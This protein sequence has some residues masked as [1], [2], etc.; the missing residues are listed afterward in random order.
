VIY[1]SGNPNLK[2]EK[3][4][5]TTVGFVYQ[6]RWG[7]DWQTSVDGYHI[8]ISDAIVS[9]GAQDIVKQ[10]SLGNA[11][12]CALILRD[13]SGG[14]FGVNNS[15][16]N[17]QSLLTTG[18][19]FETRY[20]FALRNLSSS[21]GGDITIRALLNYVSRFETATLGVTAVNLAGQ[22]NHPTTRCGLIQSERH[23]V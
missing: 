22:I 4:D 14:L 18:V 10:C 9:V 17:V 19:D 11:A 8:A 7:P 5:T 15:P 1:T 20:R 13:P 3:G 12:D 6:P 2:P 16:Q 21:L 23:I